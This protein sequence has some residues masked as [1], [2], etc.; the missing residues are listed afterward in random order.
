M[1][2]TQHDIRIRVDS[3]VVAYETL[4]AIETY[5]FKSRNTKKKKQITCAVVESS[6]SCDVITEEADSPTEMERFA[7]SSLGE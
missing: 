3:K 7:G 1:I 4:V 2:V 6:I 5:H